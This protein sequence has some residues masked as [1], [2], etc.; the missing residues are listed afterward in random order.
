ML[1]VTQDMEVAHALADHLIVM[2]GGRIVAEGLPREVL[3]S[4]DSAVR[5]LVTGLRSGPLALAS[6]PA[7]SG[8]G[9]VPE[10]DSPYDLPLWLA[11]LA[12]LAAAIATVLVVR[13]G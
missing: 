12:L 4:A 5:Q 3:A 9:V 6:D 7:E 11:A 13:P 8:G 10:R 1:V 2:A